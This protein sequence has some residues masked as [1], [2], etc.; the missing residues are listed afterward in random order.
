M[1]R[2]LIQQESHIPT[3]VMVMKQ[4]QERL[5]IPG[6]LVL[7]GQEQPIARP[8][9]HGT[10][11]HTPGVLTAHWDF[12]I[13]SP[14]RPTGPQRWEQQQ[15]GLVFGQ[16]N[17]PGPQ[18]ADLPA[19]PPF[20]SPT[21]DRRQGGSAPA[22][23]HSP[24]DAALG[25]RY[26]RRTFDRTSA[27]IAPPRA[28]RSNHWQNTPIDRARIQTKPATGPRVPRSTESGGQCP[29]GPPRLA[30]RLGAGS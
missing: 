18:I 24:A 5:E 6:S 25:V 15:V 4:P 20:F 12:P 30:R 7:S 19:D 10:E 21:P 26:P 14:Q 22:S 13:L 29:S 2:I 1:T 8:Q 27:A 17:A 3:S 16:K 9:V 28:G 23:R 11:D